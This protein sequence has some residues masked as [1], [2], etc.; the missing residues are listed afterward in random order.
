MPSPKSCSIEDYSAIRTC[1]DSLRRELDAVIT[2][3]PDPLPE[4]WLTS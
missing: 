4:E 2:G 1:R 3:E